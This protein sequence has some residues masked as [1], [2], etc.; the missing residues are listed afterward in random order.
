MNPKTELVRQRNANAGSIDAE[1]LSNSKLR[2][3]RV[4][5]AFGWQLHVLD[6]ERNGGSI[7]ERQV[8]EAPA[9]APYRCG[10]PDGQPQ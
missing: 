5:R 3:R 7:K 10:T 6:L 1:H 9:C 8:K 2:S 4:R